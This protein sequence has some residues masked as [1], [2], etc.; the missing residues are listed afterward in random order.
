MDPVRRTRCIGLSS[1]VQLPSTSVDVG[2]GG[3]I[4]A[5][6]PSQSLRS[7]GLASVNGGVLRVY[8]LR[9][10]RVAQRVSVGG[11]GSSTGTCGMVRIL[12]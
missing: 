9:M 12:S 11:G 10:T 3:S 6:L 8:H 2:E 4:A 7:R 1:K 5:H